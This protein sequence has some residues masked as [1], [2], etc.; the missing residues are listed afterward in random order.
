ML[1]RLKKQYCYRFRVCLLAA[2][3]VLVI[4]FQSACFSKKASIDIAPTSTTRVAFFPFNISENKADFRW[5]AIAAPILLEKASLQTREFEIIPLWESMPVAIQAAGQNRILTPETVESASTWLTAKWAAFGELTP[6]QNGVTMMID[7][8]PGKSNLIPFRYLKSGKTDWME[9]GSQEAFDQF[10]RYLMIP[11]P[12]IE[13]GKKQEI[14]SLRNLAE[15]LDREYGW[16]V[17]ADPGKAQDTVT[18]L[19]KTDERL[20]RFL[21]SPTLY[22]ILT[23]K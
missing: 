22:P 9:S 12:E 16:F 11:Q 23:Q 7:F 1:N 10:K 17:E 19:M 6:T 14:L 8:M 18:A 15:V 21:F 13:K 20:A 2:S 4:F 3:A 5:T